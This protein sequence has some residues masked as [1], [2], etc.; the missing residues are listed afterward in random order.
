M[1]CKKCR[2]EIAD[3]S[4]FCP[5]C[6]YAFSGKTKAKR[7]VVAVLI[8]IV[9]LILPVFALLCG[10]YIGTT[11]TDINVNMPDIVKIAGERLKEITELPLEF[12]IT[13]SQLNEVIRQNEE[14]M[15][16]LKNVRI[17]FPQSGGVEV[18]GKVAKTDLSSVVG[19]ELPAIVMLFLPDELDIS[20]TAD[21]SVKDGRIIAGISSV[22]VA[23]LSLDQ[24][25]LSYIGADD[26]LADI[27]ASAIGEKYGE[28]VIIE[29]IS[30][31]AAA[32][33]EKA[34]KLKLRYF[35]GK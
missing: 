16:P 9:A 35:A 15:K 8:I 11:K 32:S 28:K 17:T 33:G 2:K 34:I 24:N 14:K 5:S 26:I 4:R 19:T 30:V 27:A 18:D 10:I 22:S 29:D 20:I 13:Q 31:T 6:G 1:I 3:E 21:P 7:A 25:T 23:G 12:E